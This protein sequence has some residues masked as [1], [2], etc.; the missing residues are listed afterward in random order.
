GRLR[1][2]LAQQHVMSLARIGPGRR[3]PFFDVVRSIS[4]ITKRG[5]D[6]EHCSPGKS[7][8]SHCEIHLFG[9]TPLGEPGGLSLA[10]AR[11]KPPAPAAALWHNMRN[12]N[13]NIRIDAI[14][15]V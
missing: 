6:D 1:L 4:A 2:C 9:V 13:N 14:N 10:T 3:G 8:K 7:S 15:P 12:N 5:R 11:A